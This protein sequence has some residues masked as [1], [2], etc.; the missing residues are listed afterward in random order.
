MSNLRSLLEDI[1]DH[2]KAELF[3]KPAVIDKGHH[4]DVASLP[5][6]AR[7]W[8]R[9][10]DAVA[11]VA[12]MKNSTHLA[13]RKD[14]ASTASIYDAATGGVV[15]IYDEFDADY[16]AI[17]GDGGLAVFWGDRRFERALCAGITIKTFSADFLVPRLERKW[18]GI[19]ATGLKVG[20]ASSPLLVK[21]VGNPSNDAQEPVWAGRA[22]G[23]ATQAARQAD[24]HQILVTGSV[25]AW[26]SDRDVLIAPCPC[27]PAVPRTWADVVIES[28]PSGDGD[29]A[30]KVLGCCWCRAHGPDQCATILAGLPAAPITRPIAG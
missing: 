15:R 2:V 28:L 6:L 25:W 22:V 17:H 1:D 18:P 8:H 29:R 10:T 24:R 9:L 23:Y 12:D 4:L 7:V 30:G 14:A 3:S 13:K 11:V 26:A 20:I 19:V 21:R 16:I 5:P 27:A